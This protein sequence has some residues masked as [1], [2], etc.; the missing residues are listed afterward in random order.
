MRL[1][2][3]ASVI[4]LLT[5]LLPATVTAE[6]ETVRW[7]DWQL[8]F[9]SQTGDWLSLRW[10]G[11]IIARE[12][13]SGNL[14]SVDISVGEREGQRRWLIEGR[15]STSRLTYWHFDPKTATLTLTREVS[16][17]KGRWQFQELIQFGAFDNPN[18]IT[19]NLRLTWTG[20][21]EM[22]PSGWRTSA[23][24]GVGQL[25]VQQDDTEHCFLST[26]L[27]VTPLQLICGQRTTPSSLPMNL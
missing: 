10:R 16:V 1:R 20:N 3:S 19:R 4:A 2:V 23:E 15:L 13:Q 18:R 27:A 26:M 12:P 8:T 24:W 7:N 9:D 14:A 6:Q 5:I 22:R 11:Q 17:D 25:L 21:F